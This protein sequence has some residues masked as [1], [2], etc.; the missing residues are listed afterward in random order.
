MPLMG[1][2]RMAARSCA[3]DLADDIGQSG[4]NHNGV[5]ADGVSHNMGVRSSVAN[6]MIG[7]Q[8]YNRNNLAQET[9]GI[10]QNGENNLT[11]QTIGKQQS[12]NNDMAI[13]NIGMQ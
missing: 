12:G 5:Q 8:Q 9:I 3:I 7:T 4:V 11:V 13:Q 6:Q 2:Y 1:I 10:Q